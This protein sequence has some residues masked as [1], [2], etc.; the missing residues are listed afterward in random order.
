ME[1]AKMV[2]YYVLMLFILCDVMLSM[3]TIYVT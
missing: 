1:D 2:K 3:P